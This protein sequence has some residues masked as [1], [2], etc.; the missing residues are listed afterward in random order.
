[1]RSRPTSAT[2]ALATYV[3]CGGAGKSLYVFGVPDSYEEAVD[4]VASVAS[5]INESGETEVPETVTWSRVRYTGY[6]LLV[7]DVTPSV[8]G[9]ATMLVRGLNE[10]GAEIDTFALSC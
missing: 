3:T 2:A 7:V 4:N 5:Y 1:M 8:F 9:S 6:C 10:S